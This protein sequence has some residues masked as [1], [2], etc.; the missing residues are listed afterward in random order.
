MVLIFLEG[1]SQTFQSHIIVISVFDVK[2][3]FVELHA[4]KSDLAY[5]SNLLHSPIHLQCIEQKASQPSHADLSSWRLHFFLF[6]SI[7]CL[8]VQG[9][10]CPW[11]TQLVSARSNK[12]TL[13]VAFV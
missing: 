7:V 1:K 4:R 9:R 6:H 11:K 13:S 5:S 2:S 3:S 12:I 10:P 8:S